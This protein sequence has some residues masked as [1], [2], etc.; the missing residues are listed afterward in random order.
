MI[1]SY[2]YV[3]WQYIVDLHSTIRYI[4]FIQLNQ[5]FMQVLEKNCCWWWMIPCLHYFLSC[6]WVSGWAS[7]LMI[8]GY[9]RKPKKRAWNFQE[10]SMWDLSIA[11]TSPCTIALLSIDFT[12]SAPLQVHLWHLS[13][14]LHWLQWHPMYRT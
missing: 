1:I 8:Y 14:I 2:M 3:L 13:N 11:I 5:R 12:H 4:E 6:V 9:K 7:H 10:T